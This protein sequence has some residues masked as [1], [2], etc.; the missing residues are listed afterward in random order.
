MPFKPGVN[1]VKKF[2]ASAQKKLKR[3][4]NLHQWK[5][6]FIVLWKMLKACHF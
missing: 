6:I 2:K 1:G 4:S 3:I 5:K